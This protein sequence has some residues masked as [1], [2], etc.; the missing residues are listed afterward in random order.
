MNELESLNFIEFQSKVPQ[1]R[2]NEPFIQNF[3]ES[4]LL[5]KNP[6]TNFSEILTQAIE[7]V[8]TYQ[9]QANTAM[10]EL[11]AGKN[12]NIHQTVLTVE[13]ADTSLKLMMQF[14]NKI[15]DAYREVMRMPM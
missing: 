10:H 4:I 7:K 6:K 3:N 1:K 5:D 9:K 14:R 12:K 8:N 2:F 13:L 11:I 15:L